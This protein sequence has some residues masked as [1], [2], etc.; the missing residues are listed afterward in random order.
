MRLNKIIMMT[1]TLFMGVGGATNAV[2]EDDS[3]RS[4][5]RSESGKFH[6]EGR[7]LGGRQLRSGERGGSGNEV[8]RGERGP[9]GSKGRQM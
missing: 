9:R 7:E 2:A 6:H 8:R 1:A 3:R 4:E 5:H